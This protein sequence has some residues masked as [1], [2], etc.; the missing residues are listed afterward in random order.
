MG[1]GTPEYSAV[2]SLNG[3]LT[4]CRVFAAARLLGTEGMGHDCMFRGTQSRP[5]A[6]ENYIVGYFGFLIL[7][8][9]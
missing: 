9:K 1:S 4:H 2:Y 5:L 6:R 7:I 3:K 8:Y